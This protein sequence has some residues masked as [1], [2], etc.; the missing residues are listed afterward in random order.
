MRFG[1]EFGLGALLFALAPGMCPAASTA[2]VSGVVRDS[3]GVAQIGAM[4]QV[5]A[6]GSASV[7][8]AF[9]DMYGRYRI[10][11]LMP[12]RYQVRATAALFLPATRPNLLL[13]TGMRATVNLTLSMLADPVVWLPAVRRKP[14]EPGDDWR[15]TL[16]ST[17]NRPI[18]RMMGNG[19]MVL[20]RPGAGEG[21]RNSTMQARASVASG[22][23]GFG[24]GGVHTVVGLDR[25]ARDGSNAML[26][27]DLA[28]QGTGAGSGLPM[29]LDA[30]YE[31]QGAFG[32]GS[33]LVLSYASHPEMMSSG[34]AMGMQAGTQTGIQ[35][36]RM[37]SA[38]KMQLGDSVDVE[39]GAT[40]YAIHTAGDALTTQPFLRVTVHP[41]EVWA[42]RYKLATARDLQ[43]FDDLDSIAAELPVA[44]M[45]GGRLVTE[46]GSHQEVSVARKAG[47]G[48]IEAAVY[49]D[50]IGHS[51]IAGTGAMSAADL[52]AGAGSSGV[53]VDTATG[54]FRFLSAG[55]AATG[56]RLT[57]SEPLTQNLWAAVEY[58]SGEALTAG[59]AQEQRLPE[60][61]FGMRPEAT[62]AA[63]AEVKG[64]LLRTGTKLRAAYRWQP[65]HLITG[66]DPYAPDGDQ[67]YLSFYVRQAVRWGDRL[68]PG[69]EATIDV[70]NLLAQ[71][72]QPFLSADG[73]TLFLAQSPR[74]VQGGL[75][76][77]F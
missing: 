47:N 77:T 55:Y 24:C 37:A 75:S 70:T 20:V 39:A 68:P 51:E 41:G 6:A 17:A 19:E 62:N 16:R 21:P 7:A 5:L 56:M 38:E 26:R 50:A 31:R 48:A 22:D 27:S 23:G 76:F 66:V 18:L 65:R 3:Q 61:A 4:V 30:G 15:W 12:G 71:G 67:A 36:V 2:A 54:S 64:K 11:N 69:L 60:V 63:M 49:H 14:D 34:G 40:V 59:D 8:T 72:Y 45:S 42:V 29:E 9:T 33:R 35:A 57:I 25:T 52:A 44:A 32:G 28:A 10:A 53:V 46:S 58:E 1:R 13:A 74:T 43:G 73:R